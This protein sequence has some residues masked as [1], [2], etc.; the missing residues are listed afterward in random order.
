MSILLLYLK[1]L[2]PTRD[3]AALQKGCGKCWR[4]LFK[5][6][7]FRSPLDF[8]AWLR[9]QRGVHFAKAVGDRV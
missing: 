3:S 7:K 8:R 1:G 2:E 4:E 5:C 6:R 9:E